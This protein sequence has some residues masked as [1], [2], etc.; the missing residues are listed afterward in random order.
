MNLAVFFAAV[1]GRQC[2]SL[3]ACGQ[4]RHKL[5]T[6]SIWRRNSLPYQSTVD[7]VIHGIYYAVTVFT[8]QLWFIL[9]SYG[10]YYTVAVYTI[11]L[12]YLLYS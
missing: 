12:R 10:I 6:V 3:E 5:S 11:Q 2:C 4:G 9:Y 1:C 8:V 7:F